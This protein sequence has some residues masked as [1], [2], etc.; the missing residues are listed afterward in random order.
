MLDLTQVFLATGSSC[1]VGSRHQV[2]FTLGC[3]VSKVSLHPVSDTG[4]QVLEPTKRMATSARAGTSRAYCEVEA[5]RLLVGHDVDLL[6]SSTEQTREVQP[7]SPE[8][9]RGLQR[10]RSLHPHSRKSK[11][12]VGRTLGQAEL[13]R[14]GPRRFSVRN[15]GARTI[16]S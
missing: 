4:P 13:V 1:A 6:R 8:L 7:F 15:H 9:G 16:R 12:P 11:P 5:T 10:G 2:A 14:V 3:L